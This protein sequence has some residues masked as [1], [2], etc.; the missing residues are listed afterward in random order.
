MTKLTV[1]LA[2]IVLLVVGCGGVTLDEVRAEYNCS[3]Y[4]R[5]EGDQLTDYIIRCGN[6]HLISVFDNPEYMEQHDERIRRLG[7]ILLEEGPNYM[8]HYWDGAKY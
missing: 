3:R 5:G 8:V 2:A 6:G 1:L 7:A 4:E